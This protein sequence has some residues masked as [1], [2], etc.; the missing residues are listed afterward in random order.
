MLRD[1]N[2]EFK[3]IIKEGETRY[4]GGT[5]RLLGG[6]WSHCSSAESLEFFTFT[7]NVHIWCYDESRGCRS[8]TVL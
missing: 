4:W 3:M 7:A 6:Y 2:T 5:G 8:A 1:K